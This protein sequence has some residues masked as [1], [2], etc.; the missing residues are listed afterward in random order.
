MKT[1]IIGWEDER[2]S[3]SE[4]IVSSGTSAEQAD[5]LNSAKRNHK[6]PKGIKKLTMFRLEEAESAVFVAS[7]VGDALAEA[8]KSNA[9]KL[10][11]AEKLQQ[12]QDKRIAIINAANSKVQ[13][14]AKA[15][16]ALMGDLHKAK[17]TLNNLGA[18]NEALR[19]KDHPSKVKESASLISDLE[20]KV[21]EATADYEKAA[22]ELAALNVPNTKQTQNTITI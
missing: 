5:I 6:F 2:G 4:T 22:K 9:D 8:Q 17:A 1:I 7:N 15:R 3:K 14:T 16:N 20:K 13:A 10:A 11:K 12:E 18:T 19:S 21:S